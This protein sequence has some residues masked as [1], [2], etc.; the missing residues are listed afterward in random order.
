MAGVTRLADDEVAA[1]VTSLA[2]TTRPPLRPIPASPLRLAR[3]KTPDPDRYRLLF[4]RIGAPW[5]W[6]SR[7]AIANDALTKIVHDD[8]VEVYAVL[9]AQGI[10]V[11]MVEL[12]FRTAAQCEIAYFGMVP[13]LAG[14][15]HGRWLMAETLARA[16]RPG[17]DRIGVNTCSLD[18]PG[19][20]G[21]YRAQGFVAVS[22]AVEIFVDPRARGLLA[23]DAAPQIPYLASRR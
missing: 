20:L 6:F 16:W 14:R 19:A 3:W 21:F 9:D 4:R 7:L 5:L 13:E 8:A 2:M 23:T 10:E 17:V 1:V 22:R 12:D 18:H 15:G 11:G